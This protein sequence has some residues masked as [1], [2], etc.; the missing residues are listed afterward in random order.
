MM[1]RIAPFVLGLVLWAGGAHAADNVYFG[2]LHA[3]TRYSDGSGLPSEAFAMAK[4]AG[5]DFFA[6]TEHNHDKAEMGAKDR[7]D[8]V[9]IATRHS[10]YDG[11]DAASLKSAAAK[12]NKDGIFVALYGQEFSTISSGNHIN[13]FDAPS[14]IDAKSGKF[15]ELIDWISAHPDTSG[16]ASV[17]QFNHPRGGDGDE[18]DYGRDDFGGSDRAWVAALG[19]HVALIE[20]LNAPAMKTGGVYRAKAHE[21]EYFGYLNLG[22]HL[23]PS[24]GHD[25]HYK[26]W[27]TISDARVGVVAPTL[28]KASILTALRQRH[29]FATEDKTLKVVFR[30]NGGLMGDVVP[31]P[32]VDS[33]LD[34][35][36]DLRDADE[37]GAAYR[38]DVFQDVPG[39]D[40]AVRPVQSY[41]FKGDGVR[42]LDGVFF[43]QAGEYVLVRVTQY[44]D[45]D[46][47]HEE[48]DRAWTA[49]VWFEPAAALA[50]VAPAP[51]V[52]AGLRL[53]SLIPD[54]PGSDLEN[55]EV[56][57]R[58]V[59]AAPLSLA[60]WQLRDLS[61]AYWRL[62]TALTLEPGQTTIL[63][64]RGEAL[65]LN[66][67]GDT[68]ELL[69]PSGMAVQ[70][71]S[72]LAVGV[73][74]AV[75]VP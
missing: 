23:A 1:R 4:G 6:V 45:D 27:G 8:G 34:L 50:P 61:G 59:G 13:V 30:A 64:R 66:N 68:I 37:P 25:N 44:D 41:R 42:A 5:L 36:L 70:R 2:N 55:E 62:D 39:G 24:V 71:F 52:A 28:T 19:P 9:L 74:Q 16:Q 56:T 29:A 58:N 33:E 20:V 35:T 12:A 43:Q 49:P 57:V 11:A 10:L 38:V 32:G 65:S 15:D 17:L 21:R 7:T 3:H 75:T 47:E 67:G 22:F 31:A 46:S 54:P 63:Q 40:P 73:G 48:E 51:P 26:T 69:D 53:V 60:G 18:G 72:Y 14:V